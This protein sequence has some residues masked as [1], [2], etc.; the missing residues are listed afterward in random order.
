VLPLSR[1]QLDAL[2]PFQFLGR[3]LHGGRSLANIKLGHSRSGA[4]SGI[5]NIEGYMKAPIAG[6]RAL[7]LAERECRVGK[8][9]AERKLR[10]DMPFIGPR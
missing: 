2:E 5:C 7:E 9:E 8:T 1:Q 10:L 4:L 3:P 6:G